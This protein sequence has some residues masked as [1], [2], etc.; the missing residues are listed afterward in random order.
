MN[1][2]QAIE[3]YRTYG[4][5]EGRVWSDKRTRLA[6]KYLKKGDGIE[7]GALHSPLPVGSRAKVR[8]VDLRSPEELRLHYPELGRPDYRVDVVDNGES[9][10]TFAD[11]SLD[12]IIANHFLEHAEDLLGTIENHIRRLKRGGIGYYATPDKRYSFDKDREMTTWPEVLADHD[13]GGAGSRRRHYVEWAMLIQKMSGPEAEARADELMKARYSI[14]FS[15]ADFQRWCE[16]FSAV[17]RHLRG[18][19]RVVEVCENE[20]RGEAI[21]V[22][23]K[24]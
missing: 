19:F 2:A 21:H 7:I 1:R 13:D 24:N 16:L 22:I 15:V 20:P 5:K 3:H 14:H 8:Y 23:R 17:Q 11:G 9:L 12:F 6:L 4:Q 10:S 18:S